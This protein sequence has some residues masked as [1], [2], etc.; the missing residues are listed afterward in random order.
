MN[1]KLR[2]DEL[3]VKKSFFQSRSKASE[4][5]KSGKVK[6]DGKLVDKPGK[7]I[8]GDAVIELIDH[9]FVVS[10]AYYKLEKALDSF[11]VSVKGKRACDLGASTGGFTQLLLE[12]GAKVVYAVDVG[13]SQLHPFLKSK[14]EVVSLENTDARYVTPEILNGAVDIVTADLSFISITKVTGSISGMLKAE[15]DCICLIKPQFEAGPGVTKKGG[16]SQLH[17]TQRGSQQGC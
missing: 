6:V 15:G 7:R 16:C 2:L 8:S 10:R 3:L 5:I 9:K 4:A 13:T 11:K 17:G 14:S 12:R 1:S